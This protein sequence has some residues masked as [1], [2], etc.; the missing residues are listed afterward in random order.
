MPFGFGATKT[1]RC[2]GTVVT[3]S[4]SS[5]VSFTKPGPPSA[6][7]SPRTPGGGCRCRSILPV[8]T[9]SHGRRATVP[10]T[11]G[12]RRRGDRG[13]VRVRR[14]PSDGRS[15]HAWADDASWRIVER[16]CVVVRSS[17]RSTNGYMP[18]SVRGQHDTARAD[19]TPAGRGSPHDRRDE[20]PGSSR[21][22][23][24]ASERCTRVVPHDAPG[25]SSGS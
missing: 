6:D 10:R 22:V 1:N 15:A 24:L 13:L 9:G 11:K 3:W 23:Q 21:G 19:L 18:S 14:P 16:S 2:G 17:A 8:N 12:A 20:P 7:C 5:I 25:T 4:R